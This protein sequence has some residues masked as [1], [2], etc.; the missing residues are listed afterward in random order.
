VCWQLQQLDDVRELAARAAQATTEG[1][2]LS[3]AMRDLLAALVALA[4][5]RDDDAETLLAPLAAREHEVGLMAVFGSAHPLRAYLALKRGDTVAAAAALGPLLEACARDGTP[6][7]LLME[8]PY[9]I[10]LLRAAVAHRVLPDIAAA[11][12]AQTHTATDDPTFEPAGS[13]FDAQT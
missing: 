5:G 10:P 4:D 3:G 1:V 12:L 2:P 11:A 7:R 6:G 8:G 9:I 13:R